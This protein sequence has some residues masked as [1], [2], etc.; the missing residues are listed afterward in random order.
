MDLFIHNKLINKIR[1]LFDRDLMLAAMHVLDL[2]FGTHD[3]R[4]TSGLI[5][6]TDTG[7]SDDIAAGREVRSRNV[8]HQFRCCDIRVVHDGNDAVDRFAQIVC[9]HIGRHTDRDT[10]GTID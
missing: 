1:D 9:R 4:T 3:D 10:H 2:D 6:L 7:T 8:F 5:S